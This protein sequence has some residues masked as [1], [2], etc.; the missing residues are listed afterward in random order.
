MD[1]LS[2]DRFR[3]RNR[4]SELQFLSIGKQKMTKF[5]PKKPLQIRKKLRSSAMEM[6][7]QTVFGQNE[8]DVNPPY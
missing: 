2:A 8:K 1:F 7:K 4:S 6:L 5:D 3:D